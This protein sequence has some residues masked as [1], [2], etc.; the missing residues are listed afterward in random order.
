MSEVTALIDGAGALPQCLTHWRRASAIGSKAASGAEVR[1]AT[2]NSL[3]SYY[4][5]PC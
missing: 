4:L 5:N 1:P 3:Y 2:P